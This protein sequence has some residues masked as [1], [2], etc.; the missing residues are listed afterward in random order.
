M[1]G[2]FLFILLFVLLSSVAFSQQINTN[3][4]TDLEEALSAFHDCENESEDCYQYIGKSLATVYKVNDFYSK[5]NS[6]Y[7]PVAEIHEYLSNN[8]AWSELGPAYSQDALQKAQQKANDKKAVV[9]VYINNEGLG[10]V[11]LILPGS[12]QP[13]GSWG[14]QVP[15]AASFFAKDPSRSFINKG[16]S[17][18][19]GKSIIKDVKLYTRNY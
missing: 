13:S 15:N 19:F 2:D 12:L 11:A 9:A 8:N 16:L 10:H 14:L 3:W 1:K 7:M 4:N 6:T 18:A 5:A 17:Y